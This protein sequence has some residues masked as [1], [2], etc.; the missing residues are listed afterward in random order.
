MNLYDETNSD[1]VAKY[2]DYYQH[3][4][5]DSFETLNDFIDKSDCVIYNSE[6]INAN[7]IR[8]KMINLYRKV[9]Y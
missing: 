9:K 6:L 1:N 7:F 8:K 5:I 4:S 3:G 2:V